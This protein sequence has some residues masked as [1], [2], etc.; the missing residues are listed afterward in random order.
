VK[1][2]AVHGRRHSLDKWLLPLIGDVLLAEVGN[3][4]LKSVIEKMSGLKP[5]S[6]VTHTRVVKMVVASAV[7]AE[8]EPI[9]PRKWNH[10]FVGLPIIDPTKQHRPTVTRTEVENI[11]AA[12]HPR[13]KVLVALLAASGLRIGEALGLKTEDLSPDCRTLHVRRSVWNC[14]EQEPKTA[15]AVRVVDLPEP[16]AAAL[17]EYTAGKAG[18]RFAT[19]TGGPLSQRNVLRAFHIAGATCG[20]HALRRFRTETLRRERVPE[21]LIRL[22]LGHA[23]QNMTDL[24]A[25]GLAEDTVWRQE[26]AARAGLGFAFG[27]HGVTN[28]VEIKR[29]AVA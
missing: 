19:R 3:A 9:Y 17:R 23:G 24:Y 28:V 16:L 13:Y 4:A 15:N 7:N 10:E 25:K 21:D 14:Q 29:A 8:G 26:W 6:I 1:A 27:L 18:L 11:L 20:F 5:Q 12:I 2:A 22:W